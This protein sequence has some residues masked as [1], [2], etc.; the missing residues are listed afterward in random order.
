M[1]FSLLVMSKVDLEAFIVEL[2]AQYKTQKASVRWMAADLKRAKRCLSI[3]FG[4]SV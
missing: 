4:A 2:E 3:R 1:S